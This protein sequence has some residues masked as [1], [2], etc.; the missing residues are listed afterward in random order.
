MQN[1]ES[2][3]EEKP[4]KIA[5]G[6]NLVPKIIPEGKPIALCTPLLFIFATGVTHHDIDKILPFIQ[7]KTTDY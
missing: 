4:L 3:F 7:V 5:H 1:G 2:F 6:L